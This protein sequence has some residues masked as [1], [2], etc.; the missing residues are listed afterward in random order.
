MRLLVALR[1][2]CCG[3]FGVGEYISFNATLLI[4][5]SLANSGQ[6]SMVV[7]EIILIYI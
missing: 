5:E 6:S 3:I 1:C 4:F 7:D 2:C